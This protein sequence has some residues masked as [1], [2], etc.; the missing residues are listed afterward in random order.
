MD[1]IFK[2]ILVSARPKQWVKNLSL[3]V[4]LTLSGW[5]FIPEK[6]FSALA[7]FTIF[8]LAASTVYLFNDLADAP[9]DRLHPVKCRRPIAAGNLPFPIAVFLAVAGFFLTLLLAFNLSFFF[10]MICLWYFILHMAYSFYLK[11]IAILDVLIIAAGFIFRVWAGA[12]AVDA[13]I[14]VWLLLCITSFAL[15]LAVGKRRCELT[16]LA[17]VATKHRKALL[18]YSEK[19]LDVYTSIF[20]TATWITYALFTF[21]Q[22]TALELGKS[23]PIMAELPRALV[24]QKWTMLTVPFVIY[25]VMRYVQLIYEGKGESP[26]EVFFSDR[27]LKTVVITWVLLLILTIYW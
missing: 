15:F 24:A 9:Q 18:F 13:H 19:L 5:L 12:V 7:A 4:G 23:L 21:S 11:Q 22:P 25:G 8:C 20:A 10:F 2:A 14:S 16:L 27:P 17:G 26:E 1:K 6:F 3:F